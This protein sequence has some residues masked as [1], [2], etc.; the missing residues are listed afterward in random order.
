M[1]LHSSLCTQTDQ[2]SHRALHSRDL[3]RNPPEI[4]FPLP[5]PHTITCD[6]SSQSLHY[7]ERGMGSKQARPGVWEAAGTT[8]DNSRHSLSGSKCCSCFGG[9]GETQPMGSVMLPYN[10]RMLRTKVFLLGIIRLKTW[11]DVAS[12]FF[13]DQAEILGALCLLG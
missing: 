12:A 4:C 9:W 2:V 8:V 11:S 7:R 6:S 13:G 10:S 3:S 5:S 1:K